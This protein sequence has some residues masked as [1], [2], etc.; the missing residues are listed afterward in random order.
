MIKSKR[1]AST[2]AFGL[3][4]AVMAQVPVFAVDNTEI[5]TKALLKCGV[6]ATIAGLLS[7]GTTLLLTLMGCL[8][9]FDFCLKYYFPL[10]E[11]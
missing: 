4:L 7:G 3:M 10:P 11:K 5:C 8:I 1:I 9:G 6:D 2:V